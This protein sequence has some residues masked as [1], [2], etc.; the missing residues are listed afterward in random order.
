MFIICA[1]QS[2]PTVRI[3]VFL[4]SA[5]SILYKTHWDTCS[6]NYHCVHNQD[7][8]KT[9]CMIQYPCSKH[10]SSPSVPHKAML[11]YTCLLLIHSALSLTTLIFGSGEQSF[12]Y[13][14][15][16]TVSYKTDE[17]VYARTA[18]LGHTNNIIQNTIYTAPSNNWIKKNTW[19]L[20]LFCRFN[21]K[22]I[23]FCVTFAAFKIVQTRDLYNEGIGSTPRH[24]IASTY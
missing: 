15:V 11:V 2:H 19:I 8:Y 21:G 14:I 18:L 3:H 20:A 23:E 12:Y 6:T 16:P 7:G 10:A 22:T 24:P 4:Q 17:Y 5:T 9:T 1:H 13:K